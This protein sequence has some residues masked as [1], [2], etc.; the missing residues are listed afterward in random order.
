MAINIG[1]PVRIKVCEGLNQSY[2]KVRNKLDRDIQIHL[3]HDIMRRTWSFVNNRI[4]GSVWSPIK[5]LYDG[6]R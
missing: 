4:V 5:Q 2:T 1:L 3:R 6:D